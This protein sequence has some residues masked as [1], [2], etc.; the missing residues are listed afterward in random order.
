MFVAR[1]DFER[2]GRRVRVGGAVLFDDVLD[3]GFH[4][5]ASDTGKPA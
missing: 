5:S 4:D 3:D 2:S 1:S